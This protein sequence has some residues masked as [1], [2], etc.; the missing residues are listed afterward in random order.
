MR[1]AKILEAIKVGT[2]YSERMFTRRRVS[3]I[4]GDVI[5][6]RSRV[7]AIPGHSNIDLHYSLADS[8]KSQRSRYYR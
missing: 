8:Y 7:G 3:P 6:T 4:V 2:E 1:V 5:A